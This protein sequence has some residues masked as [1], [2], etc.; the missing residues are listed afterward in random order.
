MTLI[1]RKRIIT[2]AVYFIVPVVR[3]ALLVAVQAV[4]RARI[5]CC[6]A[7]VAGNI[8][9]P[10]ERKGMPD[11]CGCPCIS[12]VTSLAVVWKVH[13]QV[14]RSPLVFRGMT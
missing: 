12:I 6:M 1:A 14:V 10:G 3:I 7:L 13:S 2:V 9:R 5:A 11:G 8:V 4:E